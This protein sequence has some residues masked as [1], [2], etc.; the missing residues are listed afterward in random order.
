MPRLALTGLLTVLV[1]ALPSRARAEWQLSPY[2][3]LTFGGDTNLVDL[4]HTAG[5]KRLL[6]GGN[7]TLLGPGIFGLEVDF[8]YLPGFFE[9]NTNPPIVL[10]SSVLTLMGNVM[11]ALP[12]GITRESLRPYLSA[13]LGAIRPKIE[14]VL[15]FFP[16]DRVLLG[17]DAGGGAAGFLTRRTGV[18]WDL[19]YFRAVK[20]QDAAGTFTSGST[21]LS[22]WRATMGVV[23]RY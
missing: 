12:Q 8:S 11:V 21:R 23:V 14:D 7:A 6:F 16:A 19:R 2:I 10:S 15:G 17:M 22:F 20:G 5:R 3:G 13:G 18:R 1:L 9:G 4:E